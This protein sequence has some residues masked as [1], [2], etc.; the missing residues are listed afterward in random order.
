MQ[1]QDKYRIALLSAYAI[2]IHSFE[3]ILPSPVPWLRLGI[4][5]VITLVALMLYGFR[6]AMMVTLI[7]VVLSSIILGTF[8]GPGFILSLGGGVSSALAM[9]ICFSLFKRF[10]GPIGLSLVAAFFHN[11]AQLLLAYVLFIQRLEPILIVSPLII[12]LGTFTGVLNGFAGSL[13][14][15]NLLKNQNNH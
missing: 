13:I 14:I 4:A 12:L 7:R 1:L 15:K 11:S 9:G 3:N 5:N 6:A 8:L 10:I 2:V